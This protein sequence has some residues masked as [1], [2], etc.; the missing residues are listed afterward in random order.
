M[1]FSTYASVVI[2]A[3]A[4]LTS[5]QNPF[6]FTTL[7][8]VT[9]GTPIN[10]TWAPSTGTV[11]TIT[12]VLRQGDPTHLSTIATI[13]PSIQNSGSFLWTPPTT[14]VAGTG[15]AFEIVDDGNTAI[16]NYSNQFSIISTNTVSSAA[17][18]TTSSVSGLTTLTGSSTVKT[19]AST[20]TSG[21]ST[22][23]GSST[24][25]GTSTG[26]AS[27]T[28]ATGKSAAGSVKVGVGMLGVV[29]AV[30]ALL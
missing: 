3:L 15:Y 21:S 19:S 20:S 7:T 5:A 2:A 13:A 6:T 16:T 26:S 1:H 22:A 9:A 14:L 23:T 30:M 24:P 25:S 12:L 27:A 18:S 8:S 17:A 29:G 4:A 11:D 28:S 10:I